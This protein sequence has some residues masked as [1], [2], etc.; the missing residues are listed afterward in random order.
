MDSNVIFPVQYFNILLFLLQKYELTMEVI[1]VFIRSAFNQ[2]VRVMIDKNNNLRHLLKEIMKWTE[3]DQ[4]VTDL[5]N[6]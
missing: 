4:Y 5:Q 3:N 2:L 6:L 1:E